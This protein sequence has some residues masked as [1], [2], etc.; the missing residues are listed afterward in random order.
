MKVRN[1]V[2]EPGENKLIPVKIQRAT[3]NMD[4]VKEFYSTD[5]GIKELTN[6]QNAD[7]HDHTTK[8][9]F[10]PVTLLLSS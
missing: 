10:G 6:W 7:T 2:S 3:A 4:A 8:D 5:I 1:M 9:S